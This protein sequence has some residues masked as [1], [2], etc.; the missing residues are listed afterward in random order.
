MKLLFIW[1]NEDSTGFIHQQGF[2][3]D[4]KHRFSVSPIAGQEK[5][6]LEYEHIPDQI[7]VW[8]TGK[9]VG[10]TA[11]VGENGAGKTSLLRALYSADFAPVCQEKR[12]GYE[13]FDEK[14]DLI[15]KKVLVYQI[16]DEIKVYHNFS[17]G[18]LQNGTGFVCENI[19]TLDADGLKKATETLEQQTV[20]YLSNSNY[21]AGFSGYITH[22]KLRNISLTPGSLNG[23]SKRFY[24]KITRRPQGAYKKSDRFIALQSIVRSIKS[25]GD[26]QEICD[27]CYYHQLEKQQIEENPIQGKRYR[28]FEVGFHFI[29][30]M[31]RKNPEY[32]EIGF[33][34]FKPS[35]ETIGE[36]HE[37]VH[38]F[39]EWLTDPK[40]SDRLDTLCTLCLNLIFEMCYVGD[41]RLPEQKIEDFSDCLSVADAIL[42]ELKDKSKSKQVSYDEYYENG[43]KEIKKLCEIMEKCPVVENLLPPTDFAYRLS[44]V[45]DSEEN[46]KRYE[47]FC[48]AIDSFARAKDSVVLKYIHIDNL[49]MSSGERALQNL[50]SWVRLPPLFDKYLSADSIPIQE[51]ILLL[52]DEIDLYMHPEWQRQCLKRFSEELKLQFP[53]NRV[54]IIISTHS[55]LVLSDV[56]VQNTIY[57]EH[58]E[59]GIKM[60]DWN[61]RPQTFGA[62]I[63]ELLNDAFF[64]SSTMGAYAYEIIKEIS[65]NLLKL[66]HNPNDEDLRTKCAPY[67]SMIK[68]IGEPLIRHKLS[69]IYSDC[70]PVGAKE[71]LS[72]LAKEVEKIPLDKASAEKLK[73]AFEDVSAALGGV[74]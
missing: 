58:G 39:I 40:V 25:A 34:N 73:K 20:I 26:F 48:E 31:I 21:A 13:K 50:F 74:Q 2:N 27:I 36:L 44:R 59:N 45:I 18:E 66:L 47:D 55:P 37:Y 61:Q 16:G 60:K 5:Y 42:G 68:I 8:D 35:N 14:R 63:H 71:Q 43:L 69:A 15:R 65:D 23:L 1:I 30:G 57:L 38:S 32:S 10:L 24:N 28:R 9:I 6:R 4:V 53:N 7:D 52:V 19:N 29:L 22:K 33:K 51:D 49:K 70:F 56:P 62:N 12:E 46:Q 3:F 41:I 64:L 17:G 54:Q 67:G 11:L 72:N